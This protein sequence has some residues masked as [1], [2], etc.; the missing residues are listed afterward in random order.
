MAINNRNLLITGGTGFIGSHLLHKLAEQGHNLTVLSRNPQN[1]VIP[2]RPKL[3]EKVNVVIGDIL[4]PQSLKQALAGQ[5]AVIHLAADYRV[6]LAP[7][8]QARQHMYQ[9]NVIGT[10]N[11]LAAAQDADISKIVYMSSTA[12][13]GETQGA[14]LDESNRHNGIFRSYYEET[15]HIA[16]ELVVKQQCQGA[17]INI[18][19]SGGVFG[20]GDNSVLAQTVNAFLLGKIPFQIA[21]TSTFQLCHVSHVCDGLITLLSPE[22]VRQNYILAGETF[23]MPELFQMLS[24]FCGR[25]SLPAKKA[26]S[27]KIPAWLMDKLASLGLTMPLSCEALHIMDGSSYT[28]SSYKAQQQLGWSAG[29]PKEEFIEYV[30]HLA[31]QL[32]S[33]KKDV[34]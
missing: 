23:S 18:A 28:Y 14:L 8:R 21:T 31:T 5:D 3:P 27:L 15:K 11:L 7:T 24:H 34:A 16:H 29:Y 9:T 26:S 12:A 32:S 4:Q 22:I 1:R 6:G 33:A 19:I 13:L 20:L 30:S 17:P 2:Y 25:P 10:S